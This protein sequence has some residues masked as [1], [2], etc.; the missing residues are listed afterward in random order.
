M[1]NK[2]PVYINEVY[3]DKAIQEARGS[4]R[5]GLEVT[6][7]LH[8][9]CINKLRPNSNVNNVSKLSQIK[10]KAFDQFP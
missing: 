7:T 8:I 4:Q 9:D 1:L 5:A 6:T 3:Y 10:T 2:L